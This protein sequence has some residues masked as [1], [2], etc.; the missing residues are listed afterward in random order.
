[1]HQPV[2]NPSSCRKQQW[3]PLKHGIKL[4]SI[5][6]GLSDV[7]RFFGIA[8]AIYQE[9]SKRFAAA[10]LAWFVGGASNNGLHSQ[11]RDSPSILC[12]THVFLGFLRMVFT[13]YSRKFTDLPMMQ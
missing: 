11:L 12:I 8:P 13:R 1:M 3:H 10:E 9:F 6:K 7:H 2:A 4:I 5:V